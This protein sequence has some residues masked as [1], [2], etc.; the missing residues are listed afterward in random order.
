MAAGRLAMHFGHSEQFTI[1][2]IDAQTKNTVAREDLNA[3]EHAP[4]LLPRWLAERG[5]NV[6]IAGGMGTRAQELFS[7]NKIEV[8]VGAPAEAPEKL[9]INYLAG[10]LATEDNLCD[11]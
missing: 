10:T 8:I 7:E 5:V 3:P 2:D 4:G 6:I 9:V 11:H 1:F